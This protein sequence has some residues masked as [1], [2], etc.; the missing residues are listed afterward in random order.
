MRIRTPNHGWPSA[1]SWS[2]GARS[3][4]T[5]VPAGAPA[6][7]TAVASL[8]AVCVGRVL[9]DT[10]LSDHVLVWRRARNV[11]AA[12][13]AADRTSTRSAFVTTAPAGNG[14]GKCTNA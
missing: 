11:N 13:A 1:T 2:S 5:G 7:T 3:N 6:G 10:V 14:R 12:G 4:T 8:S 9:H